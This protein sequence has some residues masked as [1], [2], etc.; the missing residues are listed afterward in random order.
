MPSQSQRGDRSIH[1]RP[2]IAGL[3]IGVVS[4]GIEGLVVSPLLGDIV[5]DLGV[6][7]GQGAWIVAAYG[8]ALAMVAPPIGLWGGR[9]SRKVVMG[10]G[11]VVFIISGL[12]CAASTSFTML[13][14]ARALCGM[15]AGAFLP[16]CYAYI[17]DCT[18]YE[19]RGQAM[20]R[21]MAGWSIALILGVPLGSIAG[22]FW[23]WRSSFV[24]VSLLAGI[25]AFHVMRLPSSGAIQGAGTSVFRD[26]VL[27]MHNGVPRLLLANFFDMAS[28][29]GVYTFMG[30]AFRERLN[31]GSAVFGGMV[32][33]YGLGLLAG[34]MNA[35]LL[36]RWGKERVTACALGL[37]VLVFIA[38]AQAIDSMGLLAASMV[39]WGGLQGLTQTALAT[40][41]TQAGAQARGFSTACMSCTTYLAV[42]AGAAA[43]GTLMETLGFTALC[44]GGAICAL[45]S[46]LLLLRGWTPSSAVAAQENHRV[47]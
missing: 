23:G 1:H 12:L 32:L 36:D 7:S 9:L 47:P 21:V 25:A 38:L 8:L 40:L 39:L 43:G 3:V 28:F 34:T 41:I 46:S 16:S 14:A 18:P 30:M 22:Q 27:A 19:N 10:T 20:G 17:G 45:L 42:A 13:V 5:N 15:A 4:I 2:P 11:L 31:A 6:N 24:G 44:L 35:G 37:L 33:C 26:A 29:Y